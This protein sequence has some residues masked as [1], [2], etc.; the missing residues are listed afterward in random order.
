MVTDEWRL[1]KLCMLKNCNCILFE[2]H[3]KK[4]LKCHCSVWQTEQWHA[5]TADFSQ[6][7][8]AHF[9]ILLSF[10]FRI[11]F[12]DTSTFNYFVSLDSLPFTFPKF[13]A[14]SCF[15]A[16]SSL[17]NPPPLHLFSISIFVRSFIW[18]YGF[19]QFPFIFAISVTGVIILF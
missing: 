7:G 6:S 12:R 19:S 15:L 4:N 14:R 18:N 9:S 13:L 10:A 2:W 17:Y 3:S 11:L 16:I 8:Q 5:I 1:K